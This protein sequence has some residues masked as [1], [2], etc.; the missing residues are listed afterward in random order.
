MTHAGRATNSAFHRE[1]DALQSAISDAIK[2]LVDWDI[3]AFHSAA[4]R[5]SEIC[6]RLAGIKNGWSQSPDATEAARQVQKLN[7]VYDRLLQ[8]SIHW[9]RTVGSILEAGGHSF[10]NRATVHFRG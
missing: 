8:H 2:A 1:L 9:T 6:G 7:R 3:A 5:Q 10:Q 4:E